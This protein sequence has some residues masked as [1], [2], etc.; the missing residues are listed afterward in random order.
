MT[1]DLLTDAVLREFLLDRLDDSERSQIEDLF[2]TDPQAKNRV[3][4][5]EQDLIEEYLEDSLNEPDKERFVTLHAQT[6]EQREKLLNTK[7]IRDWALAEANPGSAQ[8]S[9]TVSVWP[10]FGA[11]LGL[12]PI[13]LVGIAAAII[14]AVVLA[15]VWVNN[16]TGQRSRLAV[17]QE[18]AQL[19]SPT[20]LRENPAQ[21][22]SLTLEPITVRSIEA[23]PEFQP[24][25]DTKIVELYLR[26]PQGDHYP[27][28]QAE[29]GGLSDAQTF[30]IR[31]LLAESDRNSV[32]NG[33]SKPEDDGARAIR[34]RLPAHMF[35][36][37]NYRVRLTGI[38]ANGTP[39][40]VQEYNFAVT[41]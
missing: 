4:L 19:N 34:L 38:S 12:K 2:L 40:P 9:V 3:L 14:V 31:N 17:E 1:R 8:D 13:Y 32:T 18:L 41:R 16:R 35:Q 39:G 5:A 24:N 26:L 7:T 10:R 36:R 37:G 15:L 29:V 6:E 21:M 11:R 28:Y 20:S 33:V 22:V 27:T 25:A 23:Q 30:V